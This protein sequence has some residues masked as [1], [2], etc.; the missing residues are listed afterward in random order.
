MHQQAYE[1]NFHRQVQPNPGKARD[2]PSPLSNRAER[3]R[4]DTN[5]LPPPIRNS[6]QN[7]L[8]QNQRNGQDN[9][10]EI[11]TANIKQTTTAQTPTL[12]EET[13]TGNKNDDTEDWSDL[14]PLTTHITYDSESEE[15]NEP[16]NN[17][18][19]E[20]D[21]DCNSQPRPIPPSRKLHNPYDNKKKKRNRKQ[22]HKRYT[23]QTLGKAPNCDKSNE[24]IANNIPY[25]DS[26]LDKDETTCRFLLNNPNGIK[27]AHR[28]LHA[29][30]LGIAIDG[31]QAD[32]IGL[33]ET[34]VD[35]A[36]LASTA[37]IKA[38]LRKTWI[39]IPMHV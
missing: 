5:E 7:R 9:N 4:T 39:L 29:E 17:T 31:A 16:P 26:F 12:Q 28:Y 1:N 38:Q 32:I 24:D 36:N 2:P 8:R 35:Y 6:P 33:P 27:G 23:Q 21:E 25:G 18:Q 20:I 10:N 15:E 14:P 3:A 11:T 13:P 37:Q 34:N 19:P 30:N 22:K